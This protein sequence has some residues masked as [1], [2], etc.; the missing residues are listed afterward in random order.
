MITII[1][2]TISSILIGLKISFFFTNSLAKLL[3]AETKR[4]VRL[5]ANISKYKFISRTY[6]WESFCDRG[7]HCQ[8]QEFANGTLGVMLN[9]FAF[10]F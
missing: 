5:A 3:L 1:R 4:R 2:T 6:G 7:P 9:E 8:H 10:E